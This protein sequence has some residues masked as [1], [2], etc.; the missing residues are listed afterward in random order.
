MK[1][2]LDTVAFLWIILDSPRLTTT[3]REAFADPA[4][5]VYL[6]A[7][8]TWEIA[9]K[10]ALG[11]LKLPVRPAEFIPAQREQHGIQFLP[12]DEQSTL[13]VIGLPD[14]HRD[15]FDRMLVCQALMQGLIIATPDAQISQYPVRVLW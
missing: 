14:I 5:E 7:I 1:I 4:N 3:V 9:V 2:L 12:L 11:R 10:Y 8:S 15:P 6:S 13:H